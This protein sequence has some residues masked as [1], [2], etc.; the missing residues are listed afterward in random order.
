MSTTRTSTSTALRLARKAWQL[1]FE[2]SAQSALLADQALARAAGA[3][4]LP[5]QAWARL[6]RG[7]HLMRHVTSADGAAELEHAQR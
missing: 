2:D 5:A 7:Y 4:D 1:Q 6:A 3:D